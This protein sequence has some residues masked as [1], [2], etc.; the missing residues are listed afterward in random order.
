MDLNTVES[1]VEEIIEKY[2]HE[3]DE[4]YSKYRYAE[5][6]TEFSMVDELQEYMEK[7][8]I[9]HKILEE[10]GFGSP[11]YSNDFMAIAYKVN[12]GNN[13]GSRLGLKTVVFEYL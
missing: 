8:N 12:N 1:D 3:E 6:E 13:F 2:W 9:D 7:N 5:N 10:D 11:G 4:Y